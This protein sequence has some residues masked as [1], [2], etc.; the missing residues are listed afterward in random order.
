MSNSINTLFGYTL[1]DSK[2]RTEVAK[3]IDKPAVEGTEGQILQVVKNTDTD[4]L[5]IK[6]VDTGGDIGGLENLTTT[7][8]TSVVAAVNELDSDIGDKS[9]LTTTEKG[10]LVGSV[11][12]LD[13]DIGDKSTLTTT[14]KTSIVA[15]V[16]ELDSDIGNLSG[17]KTTKKDSVVNSINELFD[18]K[19]DGPTNT[20]TEGQVFMVYDDNGTKKAK[21]MDL[22]FA[23]ASEVEALFD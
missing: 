12:E 13:S 5:E 4:A 16:N 19:V 22:T 7:N 6:W 2:A 3:K 18:G 1:A 9:T 21:Y 20:N 14:N 10:S 23:T 11:N 8:K 17:L 15:S